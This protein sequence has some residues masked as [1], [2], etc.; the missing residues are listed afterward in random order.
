MHAVAIE[1]F[2]ELSARWIWPALLH[3][4]WIGLLVAAVCAIVVNGSARLSHGA[5]Y[6]ILLVALALAI[7]GP[8][9]VTVFERR[10]AAVTATTAPELVITAQTAPGTER[11]SGPLAAHSPRTSNLIAAGRSRFTEF[12]SF[13]RYGLA[14]LRSSQ[15][16]YCWGRDW[17]AGCAMRPSP[18]A[19]KSK[20]RLTRWLNASGSGARRRC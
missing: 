7:L 4:V 6:A 3:S 12:L 20:K 17:F 2:Q 8:A 19:R 15:G 11:V 5:R 13:S 1:A 10:L 18:R 14:A 9:V 16:L